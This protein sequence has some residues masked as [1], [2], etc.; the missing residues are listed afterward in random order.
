[1]NFAHLIRVAGVVLGFLLPL[2]RPGTAFAVGAG[3]SLG[4]AILGIVLANGFHCWFSW[5]V[6]AFVEAPASLVAVALRVLNQRANAGE[7]VSSKID[8]PERPSE[9][10]PSMSSLADDQAQTVVEPR[11]EA[12]PQS[13]DHEMLRKF[14]GGSYGQVWIAKN[15]LGAF[16]AVKVVFRSSFESEAPFERE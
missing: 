4:V 11:A 16:R 12:P 3:S 6:I 1:M 2:L 10:I 7:E 14:G 8:L 5:A 13:P 9:A 15:A